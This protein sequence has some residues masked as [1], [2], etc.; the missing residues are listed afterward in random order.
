[1]PH[2]SFQCT[3]P[4]VTVS[5]T[6]S[7]CVSELTEQTSVDG[8]FAEISAA[9]TYSQCFR[10]D[11]HIPQFQ[12]WASPRLVCLDSHL[13]EMPVFI[14]A[15]LGAIFTLNG[16]L[17]SPVEYTL[18]SRVP[19]REVLFLRD[20]FSL[21]ACEWCFITRQGLNTKTHI[22]ESRKGIQAFILRREHTPSYTYSCFNI[23][24]GVRP[25]ILSLLPLTARK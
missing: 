16:V 3:L 12:Q 8:A 24:P 22:P 13:T 9:V 10:N 17:T 18:S 15:A 6:R 4:S 25:Q 1:M 14:N 20:D 23:Y 21:S 19:G 5:F 2:L 11:N 7:P